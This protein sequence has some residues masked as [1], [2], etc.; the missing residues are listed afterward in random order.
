MCISEVQVNGATYKHLYYKLSTDFI[1]FFITI[2]SR[3]KH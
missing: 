3:N 1:F 2:F